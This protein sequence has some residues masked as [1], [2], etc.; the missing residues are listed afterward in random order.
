MPRSSSVS[1]AAAWKDSCCCLMP[2]WWWLSAAEPT[3]L[4]PGC[5]LWACRG[6][7]SISRLAEQ[8]CCLL[9]PMKGGLCWR[10]LKD[11][12]GH[13]WWYYQVLA[14]Q[15]QRL[16]KGKTIAVALAVGVQAYYVC[17][18]RLCTLRSACLTLQLTHGPSGR[19]PPPPPPSGVPWGS[20]RC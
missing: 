16:Q 9:N 20:G 15:Q 3:R 18:G 13:H 5:S 8:S 12:Y 10:H 1:G 7:G 4:A 2:S 6:G 17:A 14:S 11:R 19:T